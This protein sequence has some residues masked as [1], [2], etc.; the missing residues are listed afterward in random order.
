MDAVITRIME[1]EKRSAADVERAKEAYEKNIEAHRRAL[2][3]EKE[4]EQLLII[5]RENDRLTEDL[6]KLNEQVDAAY[7][8]ARKDYESLFQ[9]PAR[10]DAIK[11]KCVDILLAG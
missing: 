11:E 2:E 6:W 5:A 9:D 8:A 7:L 10:V 1:I 3:E 4:R